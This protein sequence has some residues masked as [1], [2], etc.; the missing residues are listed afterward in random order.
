MK[1]TIFYTIALLVG[2]ASC[3]KETSIENG[4]GQSG[5]FTAKIDGVQWSASATKQG[6]SI[7]G[8]MITVTGISADNKEISIN[9]ADSVAG[10]Y[11]LNQAS[12]S[13][14]AYADIDSSDTYA[15]ASNQGTDTSQAGGLVTI[16]EID[17]VAKTI[18]GTFSFKVY[19]DLD[20]RQK[21]ITEGVFTKIPYVSAVPPTSGS[22]TLQASIDN[23]AWSAV[24]IQALTTGGQITIVGA[25]SDGTQSIGLLLPANA[26]AG[27]YPLDGTN[28]SYL[29]AYTFISNSSSTGFVS[30]KGTLTITENNT[31]TFRVKGTFTFTAADP[32][33]GTTTTHSIT[34]G[35]FSVYYGQ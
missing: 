4:N 22:D 1:K 27:S 14:A 32:T 29:G 26:A 28:P 9:I 17:P 30:T 16:T 11:V 5:N 21:T 3:K 10:T 19:R 24:N 31:S 35:S 34:S 25:S 13:I 7:L 2:F 6:A 33:R 12:Q 20:G 15:F 23:K 8:G 18:S